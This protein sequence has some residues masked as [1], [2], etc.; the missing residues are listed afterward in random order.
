M[1]NVSTICLAVVLLAGCGKPEPLRITDV[2]IRETPPGRTVTAA[3]MRIENLT[4]ANLAVVRIESAVS[5]T[6]ELHTMAYEGEMMVM[7]QVD[8][9]PVP[10]RG[11]VNLAPGGLHVMLFGV[12]RSLVEG[13]SVSLVA[14]LSDGIALPVTAHIKSFASMRN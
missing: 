6:V 4:D 2:W 13:D 9:I 1:R 5:D 10:A 3:F 11:T 12:K 14:H 8:H 7:K